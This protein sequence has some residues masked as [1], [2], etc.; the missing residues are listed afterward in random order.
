M[1]ERGLTK[2]C[3]NLKRVTSNGKKK[4]KLLNTTTSNYCN[5]TPNYKL[6]QKVYL[7]S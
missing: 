6:I 2:N 7:K 5:T 1:K 4:T 3:K